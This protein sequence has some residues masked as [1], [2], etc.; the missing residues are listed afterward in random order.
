MTIYLTTE[1]VAKRLGITSEAT[2]KNWLNGMPTEAGFPGA[3]KSD[4]GYWLFPEEDVEK[5]ATHIEE[6][7]AKNVAGDMTP[8]DLDDDAEPPIL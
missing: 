5:V 1:Q 7:K 6:I 4:G 3:F 8:P 2:I